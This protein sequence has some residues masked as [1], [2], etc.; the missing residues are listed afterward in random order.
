MPTQA[1]IAPAPSRVTVRLFIF[2]SFQNDCPVTRTGVEEVEFSAVILF[3]VSQP[4]CFGDDSVRARV[5]QW[6]WVAR[7]DPCK[8]ATSQLAGGLQ[9][10]PGGDL[11]SHSCEG[12][13]PSARGALTT[14]F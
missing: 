10:D 6:E 4:R 11:L 5:N 2:L 3:P 1:S 12:A 7:W 14:V 9:K 13:V 8:Q